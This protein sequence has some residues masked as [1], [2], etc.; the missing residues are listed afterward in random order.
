MHLLESRG[1]HLRQF[2]VLRDLNRTQFLHLLN[3]SHLH[4]IA[5]NKVELDKLRGLLLLVL[6]IKL[7]HLLF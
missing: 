7:V 5:T 3:L 2:L 4:R 1:A 6:A